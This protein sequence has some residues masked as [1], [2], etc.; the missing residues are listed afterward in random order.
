MLELQKFLK[1]NSGDRLIL[2]TEYGVYSKQHSQYPNLYQFA[3]DQIE[4]SKIKD[5]PIVRESRGIILDRDN[6]WSVVA[7]PCDRFFNWGENI[8]EVK[9]DW[10]SFVAQEKVDG[11]LMIL[12]N[13]LGK[14]NV[15]TKGSIDA[16]GTVGDNPFTFAELFWETFKQQMYFVSDLD[17]RN[18]Y[19]FELTSKYN[20]VVTSQLNNE[21]KLT[22]IGVRDNNTGQEFP[23]SLYKDIFDVVRSY[24][25]NTID[26][27]LIAAKEL[28]PSKQEGFVLVDKNYN[29]IKV[30][31]EK[32]V[33][34]HHLKDSV[35]D[36]RIVELIRT[37][38]DSEV[39]AYFP[40]IKNRYDEIEKRIGVFI[41][42]LDLFW[43]LFIDENINMSK[44]T[45]KEFALYVQNNFDE[46]IH[47]YFYMR[48]A[49]KVQNATEW[50]NKLRPEKVLEILGE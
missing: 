30:K 50:M 21:G 48:R 34:I 10:S 3:Y 20:R 29:R 9:F 23:V 18:T 42:I 22:L 38:E 31:S 8:D 39:F 6:S 37:G 32:Y 25:M 28:D 12:Y 15:A 35:N 45:Q 36:E 4:S 11:S 13:Y 40:D 7:R 17:P 47:A 14:W 24:D 46:S 49:G 1:T 5:H 16:N 26:E 33:L 27:I 41:A 43:K 19:M 2:S 44:I